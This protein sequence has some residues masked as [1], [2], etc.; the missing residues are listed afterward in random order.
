[1]EIGF[2]SAVLLAVGLPLFV[3]CR[4]ISHLANW[5]MNLV[6]RLGRRC[7]VVANATKTGVEPK[8]ASWFFDEVIPGIFQ[9]SISIHCTAAMLGSC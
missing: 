9:V 4:R 1:M 8:M 7:F 6:A 5:T 2:E 3:Q